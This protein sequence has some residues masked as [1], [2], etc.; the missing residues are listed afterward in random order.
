MF[1]ILNNTKGGQTK[2][3]IDPGTHQPLSGIAHKSPWYV[4]PSALLV[5][6]L[7]SNAIALPMPPIVS[8]YL[9]LALPETKPYPAS[10]VYA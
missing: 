7:W 10:S 9:S 5:H 8:P 3:E 6:E 4:D 2:Q 1:P